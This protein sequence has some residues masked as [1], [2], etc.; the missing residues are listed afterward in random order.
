MLLLGRKFTATDACSAGLVT[1]VF[2]AATFE[3]EV[4]ARLQNVTKLMP[5]SL[6]ESKIFIRGLERD[7]LHR[8][9]KRECELLT[10]M[11][12]SEECLS[13]AAKFLSKS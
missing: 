7:Q 3:K 8:V 1:E 10:D 12:Q 11:Q 13:A 2:P 4:R 6:K 5:R 9:N